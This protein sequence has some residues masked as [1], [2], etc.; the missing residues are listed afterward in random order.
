MG[1][2]WAIYYLYLLATSISGRVPVPGYTSYYPTG[3]RIINY[4]DMAALLSTLHSRCH[5]F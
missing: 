4:P 1:Y 3:T 2:I 5:D